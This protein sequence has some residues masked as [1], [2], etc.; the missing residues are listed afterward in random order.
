MVFKKGG[1]GGCSREGNR[2][3]GT[4]GCSPRKEPERGY[5]RV[6]PRN[7]KPRTRVHSKQPPF[8]ETTLFSP[9]ERHTCNISPTNSSIILCIFSSQPAQSCIRGCKHSC[10]IGKHAVASHQHVLRNGSSEHINL[11]AHMDI[12]ENLWTR[13]PRKTDILRGFAKGWFS[14]R[15]VL[16]DVPPERKLEREGTFGCS[17]GTKKN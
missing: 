7:E 1:L 9:L 11:A 8:Y 6:F 15:V 3:E 13:A 16:T 5:V 10:L 17:P 2:N 14:K 12:Q 4:F